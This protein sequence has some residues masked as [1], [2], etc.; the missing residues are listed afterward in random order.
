LFAASFASCVRGHKGHHYYKVITDKVITD[1]SSRLPRASEGTKVIIV[2]RSS[3]IKS[4]LIRHHACLVRPRAR[5]WPVGMVTARLRHGFLHG[6]LHG[7]CRPYRADVALSVAACHALLMVVSLPVYC[8]IGNAYCWI[9]KSY[10][11]GPLAAGAVGDIGDS[12]ASAAPALRDLCPASPLSFAS[13]GDSL[14][15]GVGH[16]RRPFQ[17]L[18]G[19]LTQTN[20]R[21]GVGWGWGGGG[22]WDGMGC[23][24]GGTV[25]RR[26]AA[27]SRL[28]SRARP[29]LCEAEGAIDIATGPM[30]VKLSPVQPL[31]AIKSTSLPPTVR[32]YGGD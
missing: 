12:T 4:S 5:G 27:G 8:W 1:T 28:V 2:V 11:S 21:G 7:F 23:V 19:P 14:S 30:V 29:G 3:L 25:W 15:A 20:E 13:I 17:R 31:S 18:S 10:S 22:L 6:S 32:G 26:D 24:V 16:L 9:R